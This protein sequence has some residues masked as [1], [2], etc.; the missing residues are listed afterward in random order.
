MWR[1]IHEVCFRKHH[2]LLMPQCEDL[3]IAVPCGTEALDISRARAH[4]RLCY[5]LQRIVLQPLVQQTLASHGWIS[6]RALHVL[7]CLLRHYLVC[8]SPAGTFKCSRV[9]HRCQ[10]VNGDRFTTGKRAKGKSCTWGAVLPDHHL[11]SGHIRP[12]LLLPWTNHSVIKECS[13]KEN[14]NVS[15]PGK[16]APSNSSWR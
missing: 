15:Y 6:P 16:I 12:V 5:H 10:L 4:T 9:Q 8:L 11:L 14:L 7:K 1:D 2:F 3:E 13:M